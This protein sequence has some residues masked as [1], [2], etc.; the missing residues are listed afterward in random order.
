MSTSA[1][2]ELLTGGELT[3]PELDAL[4]AAAFGHQATETPGDSAWPTTASR[5]SPPASTTGS[6]ASST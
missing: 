3:D 2:I 4:H 1:D 6:W 5:G